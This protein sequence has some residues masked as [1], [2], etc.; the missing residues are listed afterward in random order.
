MHLS[1][2]NTDIAE[3]DSEMDII[4]WLKQLNQRKK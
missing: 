4:L 2:A 1:D 3:N